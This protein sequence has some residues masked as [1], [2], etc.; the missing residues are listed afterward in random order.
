MAKKSSQVSLV[1]YLE[2]GS[3]LIQWYVT[4]MLVEYCLTCQ[5][6]KHS[7]LLVQ[8]EADLFGGLMSGGYLLSVFSDSSLFLVT[9]YTWMS[10]Y[11]VIN[12]FFFLTR[13]IS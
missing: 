1:Q 2:M 11:Q 10:A 5:A 12:S 6:I 13:N 8:H 9:S 4:L 3:I 7:E